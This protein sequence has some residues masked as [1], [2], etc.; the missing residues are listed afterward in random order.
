MSSN[1]SNLVKPRPVLLDYDYFMD[2][3]AL[4]QRALDIG[5]VQPMEMPT[6]LDLPPLTKVDDNA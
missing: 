1:S 2:L 5:D 3:T 4:G 6:I